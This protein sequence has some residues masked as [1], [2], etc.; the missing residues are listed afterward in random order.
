MRWSS[1]GLK[2]GS[3][4]Q[5]D[6]DV[7]IDALN[8]VLRREVTQKE[9]AAMCGLTHPTFMKWATKVVM[10]EPLPNGLF[11]QDSNE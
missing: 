5:I 10:G 7:F 4:K 3:V 1:K 6:E 9:A 11:I 2:R 8:K